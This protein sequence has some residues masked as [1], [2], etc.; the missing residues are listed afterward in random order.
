MNRPQLSSPF[1]LKS[2][3]GA[4]L[5]CV[6]LGPVGLLYASFWG[7]CFMIPLGLIVVCSKLGFPILL[8]WIICCIWGVKA[9]ETYNNK[10]L[11]RLGK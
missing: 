8:F 6:I 1:P 7:A 5:F 2:T 10:I 3:A 9:V 11:Q 4:L